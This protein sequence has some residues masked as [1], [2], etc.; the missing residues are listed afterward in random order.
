M[1]TEPDMI[2]QAGRLLAMLQ[3]GKP[4]CHGMSASSG[5]DRLSCRPA[6][7]WPSPASCVRSTTFSPTACSNTQ[8][9]P[10]R[11]LSPCEWDPPRRPLARLAR[12]TMDHRGWHIARRQRHALLSEL[13]Q[14][15]RRRRRSSEGRCSM[16]A[17]YAIYDKY[18]YARRGR[19]RTV[20]RQSHP[21]RRSAPGPAPGPGRIGRVRH[22]HHRPG[23]PAMSLNA[24]V[25]EVRSLETWLTSSGQAI[26][27]RTTIDSAINTLQT[28]N[29]RNA[30]QANKS[31]S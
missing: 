13:R 10:C 14:F 21:Y 23:Q 30:Y 16:T 18:A 4:I 11:I 15:H 6:P 28:L 31:A 8:S 29:E 20:T 5:D 24:L 9:T 26:D 12:L 7:P 19:T 17:A 1:T 3:A 22:G 2:Q 25:E 27:G